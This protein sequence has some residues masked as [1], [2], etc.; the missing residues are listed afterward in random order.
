MNITNK[1]QKPMNVPLP[2]GKRLFLGPGKTGQVAPGDMDHPPLASLVAAGDIEVSEGGPKP[3]E[4]GGENRKAFPGAQRG[5]AR[6][7]RLSGDR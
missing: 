6:R 4:S 3:S 1:T 2:A 5:G 7:G